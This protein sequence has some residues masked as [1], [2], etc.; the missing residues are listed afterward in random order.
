LSKRIGLVLV[1][2]NNLILPLDSKTAFSVGKN[3]GSGGL[4]AVSVVDDGLERLPGLGGK[5]LRTD[6]IKDVS[7]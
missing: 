4:V 7:L 6:T 1:Q 2:S 5:G 3:A